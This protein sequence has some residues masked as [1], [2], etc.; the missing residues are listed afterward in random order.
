MVQYAN[1]KKRGK[2]SKEFEKQ[3]NRFIKNI[4][5]R[6][7]IRRAKDFMRKFWRGVND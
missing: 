6:K 4:K 2:P 1:L 5:K 7:R 3:I